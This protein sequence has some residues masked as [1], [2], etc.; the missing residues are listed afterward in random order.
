MSNSVATAPGKPA[1]RKKD[2]QRLGQPHNTWG[3]ALRQHYWLY[4]MLIPG[5]LWMLIFCYLPMGGLIMAFENFSPYAGSSIVGCL[6]NSEKVGFDNFKMLFTGTDFINLLRNTL[7]ISIAN[8]LIAFPAPII[9]ALI[10]NELRCMW[11]KRLSQT[12]VY[13]PHFISLVIVATLTFQLFSTTE[14]IVYNMFV[15]LF[16]REHA[17]DLLSDP[18]LFVALIVGQNLWKETGYGTIIYLSALSSVDPQLYE[19]AKIDGAGRWN[20]MW[21][22][23]LPAIRGTIVIMLIMKVGSLLNTGYEQIF[24][25]QNAMNRSVSDVF[26]TYVYTRGVQQGQYSLATTA[27]LFKSVVSLIMVLGANKAAKMLGESGMY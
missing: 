5:V 4:I 25:M 10:L 24:L 14:G 16:G 3:K 2:A 22:V 23:T 27:G 17:P 21:H 6:L 13:I 1:L 11:F 19:A 20:L 15:Q 12:F 26:D 8:L 9:L 18:N 7:A